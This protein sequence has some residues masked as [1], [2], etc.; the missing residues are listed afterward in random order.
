MKRTK[1]VAF[2]ASGK[3]T[4]PEPLVPNKLIA[5][6]TGGRRWEIDIKP[7]D[8]LADLERLLIEGMIDKHGEK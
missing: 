2:K 8:D 7:G 3:F 5:W 4:L 1:P 6:G